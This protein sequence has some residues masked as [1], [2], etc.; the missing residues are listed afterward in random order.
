MDILKQAQ[1]RGDN[2]I[3]TG[4]TGCGTT[5]LIETLGDLANRGPSEARVTVIEACPEVACA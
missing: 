4:A 2:V 1:E 3:V 5:T